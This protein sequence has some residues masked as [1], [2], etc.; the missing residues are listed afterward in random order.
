[1]IYLTIRHRKQLWH[2]SF[3]RFCQTKSILHSNC[4]L[5]FV[6]QK[7]CDFQ[8]HLC[9][10]TPKMCII[11]CTC[12]KTF[13]QV[14]QENRFIV[15]YRKR[16]TRLTQKKTSKQSKNYGKTEA[17]VITY[18]WYVGMQNLALVFYVTRFLVAR[19]YFPLSALCLL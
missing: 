3:L 7:F 14:A 18:R 19:M 5:K 11:I 12:C 13:Y 9:I 8:L 15:I 1:M 6:R 17:N 2:S 10:A 4:I 16:K